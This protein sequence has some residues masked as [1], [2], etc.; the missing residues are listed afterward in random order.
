MCRRGQKKTPLPKKNAR[1]ASSIYLAADSKVFLKTFHLLHFP[2]WD[3]SIRLDWCLW[4]VPLSSCWLCLNM[5]QVT[6]WD[7]KFL[8]GPELASS[9]NELSV[10]DVLRHHPWIMVLSL[11]VGIGL[12]VLY[13]LSTPKRFVST[14][15]ILIKEQAP[16]VLDTEYRTEDS[17]TTVH[18]HIYA[19]S[20]PV[21]IR[22]AV[23]ELDAPSLS[24]RSVQRAV[25]VELCEEES[26]AIRVQSTT[27]NERDCQRIVSAIIDA[28]RDFLGETTENVGEETTQLIEK[29][30]SEL[31][32]RLE[33]QEQQYR[34]FRVETPLVWKGEQTVNTHHER[35]LMLEEKRAALAIEAS[36]I[37]SKLAAMKKALSRPDGE[38]AV[39]FQLTNDAERTNF[40]PLS[41]VLPYSDLESA[42]RQLRE[43]E[44][45]L[46]DS[47]GPGHP[48]LAL[49]RK[50]IRELETEI[51]EAE[52]TVG[53]PER[54][55][56]KKE[57]IMAY[58]AGMVS[59]LD[60]IAIQEEGLEDMFKS[61]RLL[62]RQTESYIAQDDILRS[63]LNRTKD[64][65]DAVVERLDQINIVRDHNT[66]KLSIMAE[67]EIGVPVPDAAVKIGIPTVLAALAGL[68]LSYLRETSDRQFRSL[69][70][71]RGVL[72]AP[73]VGMI[74][75]IDRTRLFA[76]P[77]SELVPTLV[78]AHQQKS[79]LAEAFRAVRTALLFNA[80]DTAHR[81]IQVTSPLAG[82]GK[83]TIAANLA[84]TLARSDKRILLVDADFR[85]PTL[86]RLF[87]ESK[88]D[89]G[90]AELVRGERE[91]RDTDVVTEID[92]LYVLSGG[93]R[94]SNPSELLSDPRFE[95]TLDEL[96]TR[97]DF[98]LIDTPP[99]MA[100][101][102][103]AAV[104]ARVDG[105]LL[106]IRMRRGC[107][108]AAER[109]VEMLDDLG[110]RLIGSIV[111][112]IDRK[113]TLYG[114]GYYGASYRYGY[115]GYRYTA[116]DYQPE[117]KAEEQAPLRLK[118]VP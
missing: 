9:E 99:L 12:G 102:D 57:V 23:Q 40:R 117:D 82:D 106:V 19:L 91:L 86:H 68:G 105:V 10:L 34:E 94:P 1:P 70:E 104:A 85:R 43:K 31:M 17:R 27:D 15:E 18:N 109:S 54:R 7:S 24:L 61:E 83:S 113:S 29:A 41:S 16:R 64:L 35:Q 26:D 55:K 75:H 66:A 46:S 77:E 79:N 21:I 28:Y 30:R 103:P 78:A 60:A 33:R 38:E 53:E 63:D 56:S 98:I 2:S 36:E 13:Y 3:N 95:K 72:R 52:S 112:G 81:V 51:E 101:T 22:R 73:V 37:R 39:Y 59:R 6:E 58:T 50:Q 96:R 118:S 80:N 11:C 5:S 20:S 90:L 87:G 110:S 32:T 116:E 111:N 14:A 44:M 84:I 62:A 76:P 92:N 71:I 93:E 4:V 114:S 47:Y 25:S 115:G 97:F 74:P 45:Q 88:R 67:P 48:D 69:D 65:F 8:S 89:Y 42:Q 49:V 108:G 100:V 107:R